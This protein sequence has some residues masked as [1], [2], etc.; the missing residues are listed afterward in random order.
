MTFPVFASGDVLNAS[1]MNAVGLWK[2]GGAS[3]TT[4]TSFS[5]PTSTF[6]T[7]YQNYRLIVTLTAL[8]SDADFTVRLRA[9]GSDNSTSNYFQ[10]MTG[11]DNTS[12]ARNQAVNG[13][14]SFSMGESDA[15]LA[16]DYALVLD[17]F[18][19][20]QAFRTTW[21]GQYFFTD[22]A[23][24]YNAGR[25]GGGFFNATTQFDSLSFISSVAS[26][27]SGSY[28]VYGYRNN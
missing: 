14:T 21:V 27:M 4:A 3:F 28:Y 23:A 5:L 20:Q 26:S 11:F 1:D 18:K 25:S 10:G 16:D 17:I 8:T 7:D 6:T 15:A 13:G 22:K 2:I 24:G 12:A 19:P 9:S